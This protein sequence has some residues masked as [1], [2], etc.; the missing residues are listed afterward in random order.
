[1]TPLLPNGFTFRSEGNVDYPWSDDPDARAAY[2][3]VT[4]AVLHV[5]ITPYFCRHWAPEMG[6][7]LTLF[8]LHVRCVA[9]F[10]PEPIIERA[11]LAARC[12]VSETTI[13]RVIRWWENP[14]YL[15][16]IEIPGDPH[17]IWKAFRGYVREIRESCR[18]RRRGSAPYRY[19]PMV[20]DLLHPKHTK[21]FAQLVKMSGQKEML[22]PQ[23]EGLAPA[24][25]QSATGAHTHTNGAHTHPTL[26]GAEPP[27]RGGL[28]TDCTNLGEAS[29]QKVSN[30]GRPQD[31]R[32]ASGLPSI[33]EAVRK[34]VPQASPG[35]PP[36][37][38]HDHAADAEQQ[39]LSWPETES[40]AERAAAVDGLAQRGVPEDI[41]TEL[42]SLARG[43]F[44]VQRHL[45]WLPYWVGIRNEVG[46]LITAIRGACSGQPRYQ[47]PP[48]RWAE[49]QEAAERDRKCRDRTASKLGHLPKPEYRR[50][51]PPIAA[52]PIGLDAP[53][54]TFLQACR[55]LQVPALALTDA[56]PV[57]LQDGLLTVRLAGTIQ[58]EAL[59]GKRARLL[60]AAAE[61]AADFTDLHF[62]T[63][64]ET[65]RG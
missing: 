13:R 40:E 53:W 17:I 36:I 16:K 15:V 6:M 10:D 54:G 31:T 1:M 11:D 32:G 50:E 52:A 19:R 35:R 46:F 3:A 37:P 23:V 38:P 20:G 25:L 45:E 63:A 47:T 42:V 62:V 58:L 12:C 61:L 29:G 33:P 59:R 44:W 21:H 18:G 49:C 60:E 14:E 8:I 2:E 24:S 7:V 56:V 64:K 48:A 9:L 43:A 51:E 28:R 57:S 34:G 30:Q 26:A 65:A 22:F 55:D 39:H 4:G 27:L 41:A 5:P